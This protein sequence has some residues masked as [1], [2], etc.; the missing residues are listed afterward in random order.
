MKLNENDRFAKK[1]GGGNKVILNLHQHT[2]FTCAPFTR[3]HQVNTSAWRAHHRHCT[4]CPLLDIFNGICRKIFFIWTGT[5]GLHFPWMEIFVPKRKSFGNYARARMDIAPQKPQHK[6]HLCFCC[7]VRLSPVHNNIINIWLN[8]ID[9][10]I[11]PDN[12]IMR[13]RKYERLT[14][15]HSVLFLVLQLMIIGRHQYT[16]TVLRLTNLDLHTNQRIDWLN[17]VADGCA[18][19]KVIAIC[20]LEACS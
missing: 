12:I 15:V 10:D 11:I 5:T 19:A 4:C 2:T 1:Q 13:P 14:I 20:E 8:F 6:M 3:S 17:F 7:S 18:V 9:F 16:Y